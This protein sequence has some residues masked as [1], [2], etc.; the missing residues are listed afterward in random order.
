MKKNGN[1][2]IAL[3]LTKADISILEYTQYLAERLHPVHITFVHVTAEARRARFASYDTLDYQGVVNEETRLTVKASLRPYFQLDDDKISVLVRT[4]D[5]LEEI[6][7]LAAQ[8]DADTIFLAKKKESKGR[9]VISER[10][11]SHF[12]SDVLLVPE[13]FEPRLE[14]ILLSTDYSEYATEALDRAMALKENL[15]DIDITAFNSFDVPNGYSKTGKQYEEVEEIM[16]RHS[17]S[18]MSGW[19]DKY[20]GEAQTV[21]AHDRRMTPMQQLL[22]YISEHP[23]DLL[24]LGSR[25]HTELSRLI[26]GSNVWRLILGNREAPLLI[27][28]KDSQAIGLDQLVECL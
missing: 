25:G 6:L 17:A 12:E 8:I 26:L 5:P 10:L 13:G 21:I 2:L 3:D 23:V 18:D 19:L 7:Q 16:R 28:K 20:G 4:G 11:I 24:V 14:S 22:K 9:G 15:E 27:V 1:W